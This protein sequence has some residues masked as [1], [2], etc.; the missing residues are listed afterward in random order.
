MNTTDLVRPGISLT[1]VVL[2]LAAAGMESLF[3]APP[4]AMDPPRVTINAPAVTIPPESFFQMIEQRL[5]QPRR[6]G[7]GAGREGSVTQTNE[8][9]IASEMALY[10]GFYRKYIDVR[11]MPA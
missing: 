9:A 8:A 11:G 4:P 3:G 1:L 5:R 6:R 7:R 2:M 10:R